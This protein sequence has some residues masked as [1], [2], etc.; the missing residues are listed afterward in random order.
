MF[1]IYYAVS[2]SQ[3][4]EDIAIDPSKFNPSLNNVECVVEANYK[5]H[6]EN[7]NK[8]FPQIC[9]LILV[10][11]L[12]GSN[13]ISTLF[14]QHCKKQ[15]KG[16]PS[17]VK[18]ALLFIF[19]LFWLGIIAAILS[20][21]YSRQDRQLTYPLTYLLFIFLVCLRRFLYCLSRKH[22]KCINCKITSWKFEKDGNVEPAWGFLCTVYPG[23]FIAVHHVLW[24]MIGIITE[25][26]WAL[27]VVTTLMMLAFLF[28]VLSSL[29]FSFEKW[30]MWQTINFVLLVAV[31]ISVMLAQFSFL[32][33][34]HQFFDESLI[35]SAI[36]SALVVIISIWLKS[37]EDVQDKDND[38]NNNH[39]E[40]E[41]VLDKV[42]GRNTPPIDGEKTSLASFNQFQLSSFLIDENRKPEI[43]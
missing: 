10:S 40:G 30:D 43:L 20:T 12:M 23:C 1:N 22:I 28:Y 3:Q 5:H 41:E 13:F 4:L 32:L 17:K 31:A 15:Y 6:F 25:P 14:L 2:L 42:D 26:F 35:S 33:I 29:Y 8:A 24:V 34:G 7:V 36:Q 18:S 9:W 16:N 38:M 19:V 21:S 11:S 37:S 27:P 39:Q